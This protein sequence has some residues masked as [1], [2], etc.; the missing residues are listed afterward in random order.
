MKKALDTVDPAHPARDDLKEILSAGRRGA[1]LTDQLLTFSRRQ[2]C[3]LQILAL[4]SVITDLEKMLLRIIGEDIEVTSSL[5]GGLGS[6]EADAGQMD[7]ILLNLVVNAR[8]AMPSGGKLTIETRNAVV[9]GTF[10]EE[11]EVLPGR[12]SPPAMSFSKRRSHRRRSMSRA[13]TRGPSTSS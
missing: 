11:L 10:A 6:V 3:Q 2:P 13:G 7:Q 1:L 4:N 9:D 8:D 5:Q 12:W